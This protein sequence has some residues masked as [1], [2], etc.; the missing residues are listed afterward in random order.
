ML[1]T[2]ELI[3][4]PDNSN[5]ELYDKI[6]DTIDWC[7]EKLVSRVYPLLVDLTDKIAVKRMFGNFSTPFHIPD[8]HYWCFGRPP[9]QTSAKRQ[10]KKYQLAQLLDIL[11][12]SVTARATMVI[13]YNVKLKKPVIWIYDGQ[14]SVLLLVNFILETSDF[15]MKHLTEVIEEYKEEFGDDYWNNKM[16]KIM[17]D[18]EHFANHFKEDTFSV[19]HLVSWVPEIKSVL[20]DENI[21][22]AIGKLHITDEQR[23]LK[24]Y[25]KENEHVTAHSTMQK[26]SARIAGTTFADL[27]FKRNY[28][29]K[30]VN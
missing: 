3:I 20:K 14:H 21:M 23:A 29:I 15:S 19:K 25:D 5:Q 17:Y 12:G 1:K 8:G 22:S 13:L 7:G 11:I 30:G 27:I 16:P 24:L 6:S 4:L 28:S 26:V 2:K 18:I 10:L 9:E